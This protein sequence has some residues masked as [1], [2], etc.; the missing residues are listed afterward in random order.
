MGDPPRS[1]ARLFPKAWLLY[2]TIGERL[3]STLS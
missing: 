1:E 2:I 3:K